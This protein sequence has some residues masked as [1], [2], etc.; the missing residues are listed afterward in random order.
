VSGF[1]RFRPKSVNGIRAIAE[2]LPP[3]RKSTFFAGKRLGL[4]VRKMPLRHGHLE[5][6][7]IR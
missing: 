2:E 6:T 5:L 3:N 1:G 4:S 7:A